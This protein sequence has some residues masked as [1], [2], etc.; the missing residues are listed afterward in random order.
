[1]GGTSSD[2]IG[3][4]IPSTVRIAWSRAFGWAGLLMESLA[5]SIGA[6][7]NDLTISILRLKAPNRLAWYLTTQDLTLAYPA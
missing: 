5:P 6:R 7:P 4:P 2:D 1:M 3:S